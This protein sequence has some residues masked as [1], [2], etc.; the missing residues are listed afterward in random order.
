MKN[1]LGNPSVTEHWLCE[2]CGFR[3]PCAPMEEEP[4]HCPRCYKRDGD[5]EEL[6]KIPARK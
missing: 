1:I 2:S 5:V 3:I 4:K 6:K